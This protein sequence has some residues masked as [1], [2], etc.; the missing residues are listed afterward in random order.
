[1]KQN[2][3][4]LILNNVTPTGYLV[5]TRKYSNWKIMSLCKHDTFPLISSV[6]V[7]YRKRTSLNG[8]ANVTLLVEVIFHY[9]RRNTSH[10]RVSA[11]NRTTNTSHASSKRLLRLSR[12]CS[13]FQ[14]FHI[15]ISSDVVT[16]TEIYVTVS[17]AYQGKI[18]AD[19]SCSVSL[20]GEEE[21]RTKVNTEDVF[22]GLIIDSSSSCPGFSHRR[23]NSAI[24][25]IEAIHDIS[26]SC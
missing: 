18:I 10:F 15:S 1:M 17:V 25:A 14:A 24:R 3:N 20:S 8:K 21:A 16:S 22:Q 5:V 7:A 26:D 11:G 13:Y 19:M 9:A 2:A 4:L 23:S 12:M 6:L